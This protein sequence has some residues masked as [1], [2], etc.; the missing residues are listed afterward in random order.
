MIRDIKLDKKLYVK[1]FILLTGFVIFGLGIFYILSSSEDIKK[2]LTGL[3]NEA[4][5]IQSKINNFNNK[6]KSFLESLEVWEQIDGNNKVFAGLRIS[7]SNAMIEELEKKYG[8]SNLRTVFSK[9][10]IR[11]EGVNDKA[12]KVVYSNTSI[13]FRALT[14]GHVYKFLEEVQE[15]FPGYLHIKSIS[16]TSDGQINKA[17]LQDIASG[18]QKSLVSATMEFIWHDLEYKDKEQI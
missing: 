17:F 8:I 7:E 9:P 6:K 1:L 3:Q 10:K 14:D 15:K 13:T 16:I 5:S 4:N 18:N 2:D 11:E 12:V